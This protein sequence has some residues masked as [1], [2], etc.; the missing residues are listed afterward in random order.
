MKY[1]KI[2]IFFLL[3]FSPIF[4]VGSLREYRIFKQGEKYFAE[5]EY[6]KAVEIFGSLSGEKSK[7]NKNISL[8]MADKE[9]TEGKE[10]EELVN[11]ANKLYREKKY[12]DAKKIYWQGILLSDDKSI[13]RNYER[14]LLML[15]KESKSNNS[16]KNKKDDNKKQNKQDKQDKKDGINKN[17][18]KNFDNTNENSRNNKENNKENR[19]NNQESEDTN[20]NKDMK[21]KS[22]KSDKENGVNEKNSINSDK[23][24]KNNEE[25]QTEKKSDKGNISENEKKENQEKET[26]KEKANENDLG[27]DEITNYLE[28]LSNLEKQ[29]LKNN[30]RTIR[31]GDN[32]EQTKNW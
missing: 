14:T 4:F 7:Y 25:S 18:D 12:E 11:Q 19:K 10:V 3:I 31:K 9:I 29:D 17:E 23:N 13:K 5:K 22:S 28:M 1:L 32:N 2:F 8:Y 30:Y 16:E 24:Q 6:D 27:K 20:N 21:E 26:T 15:E